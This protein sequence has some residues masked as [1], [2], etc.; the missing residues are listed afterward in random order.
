MRVVSND[1]LSYQNKLPVKYILSLEKEKME[2]PGD[3]S[4]TD[5]S[6]T[7][8]RCLRQWPPYCGDGGNSKKPRWS[9][10]DHLELALLQDVWIHQ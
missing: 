10:R 3:L 7:P 9:P 6:F 1:S 5:L 2:V 8:L 4:T